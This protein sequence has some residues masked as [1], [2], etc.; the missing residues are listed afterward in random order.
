MPWM[1]MAVG[2]LRSE[3]YVTDVNIWQEM[4]SSPTATGTI[5]VLFPQL[6]VNIF[7]NQNNDGD[8]KSKEISHS[9]M[10][11]LIYCSIG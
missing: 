8:N 1:G 11:I 7:C 4:R 6:R 10:P 3:S 2:T 9:A 5:L